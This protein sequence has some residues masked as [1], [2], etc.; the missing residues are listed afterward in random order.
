MGDAVT[1][2]IVCVIIIAVYVVLTKMLVNEAVVR[3]YSPD[4]T[5]LLW[6][7]GIVLSPILLA[8]YVLFF[9]PNKN[10]K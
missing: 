5:A 10:T 3:G 2:L 4:R 6:V 8:I 1:T 7:V 9:L